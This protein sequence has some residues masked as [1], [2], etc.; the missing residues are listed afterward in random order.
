M[1]P[2]GQSARAIFHD[3]AEQLDLFGGNSSPPASSEPELATLDPE[4]EAHRAGARHER[5]LQLKGARKRGGAYYTPPDVVE[6]LL[7]L[8]LAPLL[9]ACDESVERVSALRV[10]DP[11]C[12]SGNFLSSAG[13][14][15]RSRLEALGVS[16]SEALATAYG[17]CLVGIDID[18]EAVEVC[19]Q[20]LEHASRGTVSESQLRERAVC[21]DALELIAET[22]ELFSSG[23]W[24]SLTE[25]AGADKGFDLVIGN[26]PFLSQLASE[27]ARPEDYTARLR[28][29]FGAA[30]GD[31]TDTAVLFLLLALEAARQADGVVCLIQ[32][33]SVLSTRHTAEARAE[34][35]SRA[36]MRASWICEDKIF[37]ASVQV[38]A[39]VLVRGCETDTV[40]ILHNRGFAPAGS[41][42]TSALAGPTWSALLAAT[43]G[44]PDRALLSD[45]RVGDMASATADFRD[46]YYGLRGCVVDMETADETAFPP[47]VTS[48]LLDPAQVLWGHRSTRFEKAK[49]QYPRVDISKLDAKMQEWAHS[50]QRPKVMLATQTKVLEAFV[51]ADGCFIPSVPVITVTADDDMDLWRLGVLLSS[52]PVTLEAARRHLGAALSSEALKL[53]ASEVL[54]LPLPADRGA[55]TVAAEHFE[56][57]SKAETDEARSVELR[58]AATS[59]CEAFGLE[60]DAELL[61]W[62]TDCLPRRR[63]RGK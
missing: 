41:V 20:S 39:P 49:F 13:D 18:P 31:L 21:A 28:G 8:A 56:R 46:H 17:D 62:W 32:P 58:L 24:H 36:G 52:P 16:R 63:R 4:R 37:D 12:G 10:L 34:A 6:R 59:M 55:W 2:V 27:T 60:D 50:R 14:R 1:S 5:T 45:G 54:D 26:P 7:D 3:P 33:I 51:D 25:A 44:V 42:P 48:G 29:R 61:S 23:D 53:S 38:C 30:V 35:L 11:A 43:S 19:I 9:D 47:L 40:E 15:I 57:A 22:N